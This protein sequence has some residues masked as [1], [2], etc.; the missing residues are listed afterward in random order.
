Q[1][2]H[3]QVFLRREGAAGGEKR[4]QRRN[5]GA[6]GNVPHCGENLL[7]GAHRVTAQSASIRT[8][9]NLMEPSCWYCG[10]AANRHIVRICPGLPLAPASAFARK[11][12]KKAAFNS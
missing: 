6:A 1:D 10:C 2:G 5:P 7:G 8:G 3:A 9:K 12:P 11:S 4:I